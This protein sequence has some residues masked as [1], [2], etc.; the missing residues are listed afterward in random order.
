MRERGG[1]AREDVQAG[2][3]AVLERARGRAHPVRDEKGG[4][5]ESGQRGDRANAS[6][7]G[8]PIDRAGWE[9]R[10]EEP[11]GAGGRPAVGEAG[12]RTARRAYRCS[13][14]G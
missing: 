10:G 7:R 11:D 6:R 4:G 12:A 2:D 8:G 3:A 5:G 1:L 14:R 9:A 13:A